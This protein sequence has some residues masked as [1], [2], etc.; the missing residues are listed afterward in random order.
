LFQ[1]YHD[2]DPS[3]DRIVFMDLRTRT[4]RDFLAD[5]QEPLF[6]AFFSW[7][8]RWVVFKKLKS[9]QLAFL[10]PAQILIAPVR[11]GVAGPKSEWIV[12]TDGQHADDKPQFSPDGIGAPFPVE[13][14]HNSAGRAAPVFQTWMCDLS[15]AK[16]KIL[17][18]LPDMQSDLWMTGTK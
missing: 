18:N 10:S 13:H 1:K 11:H 7:D 9:V 8:G 4:E 14:F 2:S 6:H 3:K 12:V 5:P 15:I 17:I 16:D